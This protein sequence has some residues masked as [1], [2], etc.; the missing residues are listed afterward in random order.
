MKGTVDVKVLLADKCGFCF[1]VRRAIELAQTQLEN[2][3][4]A[5]S[6][7]PLIHNPQVIDRLTREGLTVINSP[8]EAETGVV[9]VRS[10][11]APAS[12]IREIETRGL[13]LVDATC[14]LVKRAQQRA[15]ELARDGY[16]VVVVGEPDH[17]EVR[18]ILTD[19][20]EAVVIE[21]EVPENLGDVERLGVIAQTTQ[22]PESFARVVSRI[23][24]LN[25]KELR[26]YNTICSATTDR[27]QAAL[28]IAQETD[29]MFVLG[30]RNSANTCR[31]AQL[32]ET[33]GVPTYHLE[34]VDE[35]RPEMT[36][37]KQCAGVTAGASTPDWIVSDFVRELETL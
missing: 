12:V 25:F 16:T 14:P 37:G 11:G 23:L 1:G 7:G 9:I 6:L 28:E 3:K 10:H 13:E 35:L 2:G 34:T 33:V 30:G 36:R 27:Q 20:A 32:C 29:V 18:A 24:E 8:D 26:V 21:D 19:I 15:Q 5:C 4:R 17:P 31:L 22:M